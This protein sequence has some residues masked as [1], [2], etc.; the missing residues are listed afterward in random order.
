MFQKCIDK[1]KKM[2]RNM[3]R[4]TNVV[5]CDLGIAI[6]LACVVELDKGKSSVN[7]MVVGGKKIKYH[8]FWCV[9]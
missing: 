2:R 4:T 3:N 8:L 1:A 6:A 9:G 5:L 7:E